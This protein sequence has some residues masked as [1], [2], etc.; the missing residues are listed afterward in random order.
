[1]PSANPFSA[2]S[3]RNA[4]QAPHW[5]AGHKPAKVS[6]SPP[7]ASTTGFDGTLPEATS[8][9]LPTNNCCGTPEGLGPPQKWVNLISGRRSSCLSDIASLPSLVK[10]LS[11]IQAQIACKRLCARRSFAFKV[12]KEK[13][14]YRPKETSF[15]TASHT[16]W[17]SKRQH[18]KRA[19]GSWP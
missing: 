14:L 3:R 7:R 16:N 9:R 18:F 15:H 6:S 5:G 11:T 10:L 12:R 4:L 13:W 1:M 19:S 17:R 8:A 2:R